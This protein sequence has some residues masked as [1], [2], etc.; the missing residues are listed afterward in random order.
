VETRKA[1]TSI[2]IVAMIVNRH[3]DLLRGGGVLENVHRNRAVC[4]RD[5]GRASVRFGDR[6]WIVG[7]VQ[8]EGVFP[9]K[10]NRTTDPKG[11]PR[12][13]LILGMMP[14]PARWTFN[15][16]P[17]S[18]GDRRITRPRPLVRLNMVFAVPIRGNLYGRH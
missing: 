14:M 16:L 1:E 3:A 6:S 2:E 10:V 15:N 8:R 5:V 12:L 13:A 9:R 4:R 18:A 11:M 17:T 7:G